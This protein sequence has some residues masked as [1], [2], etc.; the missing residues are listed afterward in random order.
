MFEN[1]FPINTINP[2]FECNLDNECTIPEGT[3]GDIYLKIFN[4]AGQ[5]SHEPI[6]IHLNAEDNFEPDCEYYEINC[7]CQEFPCPCDLYL[8]AKIFT[9][10]LIKLKRVPNRPKDANILQKLVPDETFSYNKTHFTITLNDKKYSIGYKRLNGD[11]TPRNYDHLSRYGDQY[12]RSFTIKSGK[13]ALGNNPS[14]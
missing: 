8:Y 9:Y 13:Y 1:E 5:I 6:I 14:T 11:P 4:S 7:L 12:G 2:I 10:T 3:T